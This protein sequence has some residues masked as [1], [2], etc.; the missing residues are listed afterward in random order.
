MVFKKTGHVTRAPTQL[1]NSIKSKTKLARY[2]Q[3]DESK[4]KYVINGHEWREDPTKIGI[5]KMRYEDFFDEIIK[6]PKKELALLRSLI[7]TDLWFLVRFVQ[8]IPLADHAFWIKAC[9]EVEDG[10]DTNTMD[11]WAREHGKTSIITIAES[12]QDIL[13]NPEETICIMSYAKA[14]AQA[15]LRSIKFILEGSWILKDCFPDVLY[16][17]PH[18]EAPAWSLETGLYVKRNSSAKEAS[19]EPAGLTEA[20]PTGKHYSKIKFDDIVTPDVVST[21]EGMSKVKQNFGYAQNLMTLDGKIRIVGTFYHYDD[22]LVYISKLKDP[23]TGK[24]IYHLRKK[25]ATIDGTFNGE[26][27]YLPEKRLAVLRADRLAFATQQ[28]LEPNPVGMEK[29]DSENLIEVNREQIPQ[30]LYKFMTID[31]AGSSGNKKHG[32][33]PDDWAIFVIGVV[34]KIDEVG[35]SDIYLL[36]FCIDTFDLE[37]AQKKIVEM[38]KRAGRVLKVGVEKVGQST[39][40][41]HVANA[42]RA[43]NILVSKDKGNLYILNP[44][45]RNK[46][47]RIENGL[48][49]PLRNGKIKVSKNIPAAYRERLKLELKQFPFWKNDGLDALSYIYD[50]IKDYRFPKSTY[51]DVD[52]KAKEKDSY[53]LFEDKGKKF[54]NGWM[55]S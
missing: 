12:V 3:F 47:F 28:L 20:M 32:G 33:D 14:P 5:Y 7:K 53:S 6:D 18:Q 39:M 54:R 51:D 42:L 11:L 23:E 19:F 13:K 48:S 4:G 1:Q 46:E 21:P 8:G 49:W 38:Y 16:M 15:I 35:A 27:V 40:E 55:V 26:S 24:L 36:D 45:S 31:P 44:A 2:I 29:F 10:P 22:P 34:P 37:G 52:P 30:K 50:I 41:I 43:A 17:N 9:R 25:P